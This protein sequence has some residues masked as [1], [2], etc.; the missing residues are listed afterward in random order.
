MTTP[1][2]LAI[3]TCATATCAA[4]MLLIRRR[5]AAA[6]HQ[7]GRAVVSI[8]FRERVVS[9]LKLIRYRLTWGRYNGDALPPEGRRPPN[10]C[11]AREAVA[12]VPR[13]ACMLTC[14]FAA[15]E[16][17]ALFYWCLRDRVKAA[18]AAGQDP[19]KL[20]VVA[21]SAQGGRGKVP[22]S[23][24]ELVCVPGTVE[25]MVTGHLETCK[26]LLRLGDHGGVALYNV[27]QGV[28]TSL[29]RIQ[30]SG[31]VLPNQ[32]SSLT[33]DIGVGTF[34]DPDVGSGGVVCEP[35]A[36]KQRRS[37]GSLFVAKDAAAKGAKRLRFT[38]PALDVVV[39]NARVA[40]TNGN[41]YL[42]FNSTITETLDGIRAV[43]NRGSLPKKGG[44][45]ICT[46]QEI[47]P[48][49]DREL[50]DL[51]GRFTVPAADVDCLCLWEAF[52]QLG[53]RAALYPLAEQRGVVPEKMWSELKFINNFLRVTPRRGPADVVLGRVAASMFVD[54]LRTYVK[55]ERG[56][57]VYGNLG[58]G[59][60]EEVGVNLLRA[61]LIPD[62]ITILTESGAF[63]GL[64]AMGIFFG[65]AI[66]PVKVIPS[67]DIFDFMQDNL[68]VTCLG[69]LQVDVRGN[70]NVSRRS[71]AVSGA[72]GC[73]GFPNIVRSAKAIVFIF[74]W[75]N[76]AG[77][78]RLSHD[79]QRMRCR[80]HSKAQDD[81]T[82]SP[83]GGKGGGP[84]C[85]LV[86]CVD[87][88]TFNAFEAVSLGKIVRYCSHV[89]VFEPVSDGRTVTALRLL[90]VMPGIDVD[91]DVLAWAPPGSIT[92]SPQLHVLPSSIVSGIGYSLTLP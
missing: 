74:S 46:V 63:G 92:V 61:N 90:S 8:S 33:S 37:G 84:Q 48:C 2:W 47:R 12:R 62:R 53:V 65:T 20:T 15:S 89:G 13:G 16:R 50:K 22:G 58:V 38:I 32:E 35:A 28:L 7:G 76:K 70:V 82:T 21:V 72:V 51:D 91:R 5:R 77:A 49:D 3:L 9:V 80:V 83:G 88:I 68:S 18:A 59:L 31:G 25:V 75:F 55:G 66:N 86:P 40:D 71:A 52:D 19:L 57:A 34:L 27:P 73:G 87:E 79:Q 85:K 41:V 26:G 64:P 4:G 44:L 43:R 42:H 78:F 17:I 24:D 11:T 45:V 29:I 56:G 54:S 1:L 23:I 36:I 10:A 6:E 69:A 30:A 14:G 39:F 81:A 67:Q 60:P